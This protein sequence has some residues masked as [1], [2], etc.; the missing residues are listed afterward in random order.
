MT[1]KELANVTLVTQ[2][3]LEKVLGMLRRGGFVN[4]SRGTTGGYV[5]AKEPK[6][7]T[8]GQVLRVLEK[9]LVFS[10]CAKSGKCNN[11]ACPNKS[12][13]KIIY[14]SLNDVLD[15]ITIED[16]IKNKGEIYE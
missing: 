11:S 8:I 15:S 2:P 3:Y 4:T 5:I 1:L 7:I 12:I 6:N 14:D 9:D 10:D 13:F 16:M